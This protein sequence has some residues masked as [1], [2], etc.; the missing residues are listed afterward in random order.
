M[1]I[2]YCSAAEAGRILLK[3]PILGY[4]QW[5]KWIFAASLES[6]LGKDTGQNPP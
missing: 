5:R 1:A 3:L 6:E 4:V 2:F